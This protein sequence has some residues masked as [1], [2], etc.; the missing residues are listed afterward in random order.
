MTD[1]NNR[2]DFEQ[3]LTG[4]I[5]FDYWMKLNQESPEEFEK[6]RSLLMEAFIDNADEENKQRARGLLFQIDGVRRRA[7]N[8][9]QSTIE[10]SKM[11]WDKALE[12]TEVLNNGVPAPDTLPKAKVLDFRGRDN[13]VNPEIEP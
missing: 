13:D 9:M 12:Q 7:D 6:Q 2:N 5:D 3:Q 10:L 11:M 4:D 8:P 1:D